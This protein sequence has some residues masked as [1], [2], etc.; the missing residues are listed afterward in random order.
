MVCNF[1]GKENADDAVFCKACGNRL[2]S[3]EAPEEL[4]TEN[5]SEEEYAESEEYASYAADSTENSVI[6][7]ANCGAANPAGDAFCGKCGAATAPVAEEPAVADVS[8]AARRRT[9]KATPLSAK[10]RESLPTMLKT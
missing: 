9:K 3:E 4:Y 1:C 7:C 6:V 2:V 8:A 5:I 10:R